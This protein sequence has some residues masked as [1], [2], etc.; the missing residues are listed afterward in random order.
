MGSRG[1]NLKTI[2]GMGVFLFLFYLP[3]FTFGVIPGWQQIST[4]TGE[5]EIPNSGG[6]QTAALILDIDRDGGNDFV[7]AERSASHSI[8][9]YKLMESYWQKFMIE[10]DALP[11]EAG[12][13]YTDIDGDGDLDIV[14]GT[15]STDNKMWW[16]ENPYPVFSTTVPWQR[17]VIK[18][19]GA[20]KHHDQAFGDV[21]G[22]GKKELVF[23]NQGLRLAEIPDDPKNH[24][25]EWSYTLIATAE[26]TDFEGLAI[27]DVDGDGKRDI[28]G[29]ARLYRHIEGTLFDEV[30]IDNEEGREVT[31]IAAGQIIPGGRQEVV[32]C[33]GDSDG[34]LKWYFH[35]A[36]SW[37]GFEILDMVYH[38]HSL[39]VC[40]INNDGFADIFAAEM[41]QPGQGNQAKAFIFYGSEDISFTEQL[42]S[43]GIG[44]HESKIGDL[45]GDGDLDILTKPFMFNT[46]RLDIFY[47][48]L[49]LNCCGSPANPC[50]KGDI[51][52]DC[53]TDFK[54]LCMLCDNWLDSCYGSGCGFADLN[55]DADVN[56]KDFEIIASE[57]FESSLKQ[58]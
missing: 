19:A 44:N 23:W 3:V 33:P 34:P 5:I 39:A 15:D 21:D 55:Q 54:D 56:L 8:I 22:D 48:D 37:Y 50:N 41:G 1:L 4:E 20:D 26:N 6:E 57:W 11:I 12:G 31:R 43:V 16:W 35:Y 36:G 32:I 40:D 2:R 27:V 25:G 58:D 46:P 10:D 49:I 53:L 24:S 38:G 17:R 47:S 42:I 52:K 13:A 18:N 14:F 7:I 29:A 51:N 28:L 45:D 30:I 9:W